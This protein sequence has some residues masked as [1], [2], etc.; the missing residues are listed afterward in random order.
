VS[1]RK[2]IWHLALW[3]TLS[4]CAGCAATKPPA[5]RMGPAVNRLDHNRTC[6]IITPALNRGK[7]LFIDGLTYAPYRWPPLPEVTAVGEGPAPDGLPT[8]QM[9]PLF[10]GLRL[11]ISDARGSCQQSDREDLIDYLA[12]GPEGFG[13]VDRG[14]TGGNVAA[15]AVPYA[16]MLE[17]LSSPR[18]TAMDTAA[19]RAWA[20]AHRVVVQE[21]DLDARYQVEW[22]AAAIAIHFGDFYFALYRPQTAAGWTRLVVF[23]VKP[24][25]LG[26]PLP[27]GSLEATP[28][29]E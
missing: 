24:G 2:S 13:G 17:L 1:C 8:G 19:I 12:R 21:L 14:R 3:L 18:L 20:S 23:P 16:A 22:F 26:F 27:L 9:V 4:I 29:P 10:T 7:P 25:R 11:P 5:P 15:A 28:K 6:Q